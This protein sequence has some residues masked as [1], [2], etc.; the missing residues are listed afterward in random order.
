MISALFDGGDRWTSQR[1][2]SR[3]R[4]VLDG[5]AD[6]AAW[7]NG[8][9]V[10]AAIAALV[11]SRGR[12][13]RA[14]AARAAASYGA[15]SAASNLMVKQV[16]D[17]QRPGPIGRRGP[18]K[19]TSAFPSSHAATAAA[20]SVS[21]ACDWPAA[22]APLLVVATVVAGSRV[23]ARQ[24]RI[25]DVLGGIGLGLVVALA[26]RRLAPADGRADHDGEWTAVRT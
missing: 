14:V 23:Y 11:A 15:A 9:P 26:V 7:G 21:V 22:G 6:A 1:L 19:P 20:F 10:W 4:S 18:A 25:G 17:R 5:L 8:V 24:H 2:T 16:V 12:R 13:G 3:R